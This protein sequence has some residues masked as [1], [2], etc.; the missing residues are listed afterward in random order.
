VK[1]LAFNS[2]ASCDWA[3]A[4]R[5]GNLQRAWEISD[6]SLHEYCL[7]GAIKHTGARHFQRIWRGEDLRNKRVLVRCYHG[8][9]DT[10]QFIRFARA[11]RTIARQ[12]LVWGQPELFSLLRQVDGVDEVF[13]LHDGTPEFPYDV[14]IEVMELAHALRV[15]P[16]FVSSRVPYLLLDGSELRPPASPASPIKIGLVWE[17]GNWDRRRCVPPHMLARFTQD[18]AF[19]CFR[20][21]KVRVAGGRPPFPPRILPCPISNPWRQRS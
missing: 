5:N 4:L 9:G 20:F 16:E 11:L 17:V 1:D 8:L 21:S 14:D 7:S 10:I 3:D 15:T 6:Q 18:L 12:V 19:D 2:A 13:P